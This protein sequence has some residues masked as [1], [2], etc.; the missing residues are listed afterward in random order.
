MIHAYDLSEFEV[1]DVLR[2][3]EKAARTPSINTNDFVKIFVAENWSLSQNKCVL[4][5]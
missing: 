2:L 3:L 1:T 5:L 4:S